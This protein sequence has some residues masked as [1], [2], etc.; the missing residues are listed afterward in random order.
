VIG[1]ISIL[2]NPSVPNIPVII[3]PEKNK[4]TIIFSSRAQKEYYAKLNEANNTEC[5]KN[6]P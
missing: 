2:K 6:K 1:K 3:T 5:D 4:N